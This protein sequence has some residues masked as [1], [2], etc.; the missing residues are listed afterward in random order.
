MRIRLTKK[1]KNREIVHP[2][3]LSEICKAI[4][5][6]EIEVIA[7][8]ESYGE[9]LYLVF[10]VEQGGWPRL[11]WVLSSNFNIIDGEFPANW[12]HKQWS[13]FR[14]YF[15]RNKKYDFDY[16]ITRYSGPACILNDENFLFDI[17][18]NRRNAMDFYIKNILEV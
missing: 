11:D 14:P 17:I 13:V 12:I 6:Y 8:M 10:M 4:D 9:L 5:G 18:E 1:V 7:L 15:K 2:T 3:A 16:R